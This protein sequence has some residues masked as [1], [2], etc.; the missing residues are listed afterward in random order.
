MKTYKENPEKVMELQKKQF[1]I[2][3]KTMEITMRPIMYTSIPV[4]LFFRWFYGYFALFPVK[5]LWMHWLLAYFI[6]SMVLTTVFR[7]IFN[8]A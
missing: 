4:I 6:F 8:V 5:I 3:P 7:K 2:I 1:A